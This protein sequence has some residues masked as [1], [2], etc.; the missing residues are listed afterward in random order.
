MPGLPIYLDNNA[1]TPIDAAVLDAMMPYL[2]NQFGNA[3]SRSHS[4]GWAAE[5][6]VNL[7]REQVA[8]L[9]GADSSEII[10]TSGATEAVNLAIK[11]VF[12]MYGDNGKH[13]ITCATEHKAVLDTCRHLEKKGAEITILP[14]LQNGI[15]D[16]T[17]IKNAIRKDTVLITVMY[18]NNETGVIQPIRDISAVAKENNI[19]FFTDATQAVGKIPV[20]VIDDN[21]DLLCLSAHK[22]YGPK[23]VGAL[24]VRRKNPRVRLS[25][26]IDGGGHEKGLR[27]GTLNVPGIAALGKAAQLCHLQMQEEAL[28]IKKLRDKLEDALL[29]I[30]GITVNGDTEHRLPNV[31][32]LSFNNIKGNQLLTAITKTIAVSSGSACTSANP[33]PSHVLKAMGVADES[34]KNSIRFGLGRFTTE[35]EIN[36]AIEEVSR[37]V[38]E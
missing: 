21:I 6:A 1:T 31:T 37:I 9:T 28:R 38:N 22:I 27:S 25:A 19:L 3:A 35:E 32:N 20:N 2:T 17:A 24:Y 11:G 10:F 13:I 15:I 7:A 4:F 14:V 23:G 18:A 36:F 26:Q 34:A 12:E 29:N 8:A 33:E 30:G 5:E 16:T